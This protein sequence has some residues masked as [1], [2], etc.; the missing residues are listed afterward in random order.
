MTDYLLSN[1]YMKYRMIHSS[2]T[3]P[4]L[5][6]NRSRNGRTRELRP[7]QT[8]GPG[9]HRL[10]W[11]HFSEPAWTKLCSSGNPILISLHNSHV[12]CFKKKK[13]K[14]LFLNHL[15]LAVN[16]EMFPC[17]RTVSF[18]SSAERLASLKK[19]SYHVR[20]K[21]SV[22]AKVP[23]WHFPTYKQ[24]S[25]LT[26]LFSISSGRDSF[27]RLRAKEENLSVLLMVSGRGYLEPSSYYN[28]I[29]SL[30]S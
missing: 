16:W 3:G 23:D 25:I 11:N 20:K 5:S 18:G 8:S 22:P 10:L 29:T 6:T 17:N 28:H 24:C 9:D 27:G 19:L 13:K 14:Q 2:N 12:I 21:I 1:I 30:K 15:Q 7:G 26:I 4:C